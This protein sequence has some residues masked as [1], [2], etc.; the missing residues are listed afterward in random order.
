MIELETGYMQYEIIM[1]PAHTAQIYFVMNGG[2]HKV[3]KDVDVK[4]VCLRGRRGRY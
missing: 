3:Y 1:Y 4:G 2:L